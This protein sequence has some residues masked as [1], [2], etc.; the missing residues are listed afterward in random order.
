LRTPEHRVGLVFALGLTLW[1]ASSSKQRNLSEIALRESE[2]NSRNLANTAPVMILVSSLDGKATFF[3]SVWLDFT[4]RL[5]AARNSWM[6]THQ[7]RIRES[8]PKP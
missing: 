1:Q 6:T 3:N 5:I 7:L 8:S 4:G 2:E